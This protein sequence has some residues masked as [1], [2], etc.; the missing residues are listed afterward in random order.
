MINV[1]LRGGQQNDLP[2]EISVQS[3]YIMLHGSCIC[4]QWPLDGVG[5][6]LT[7]QGSGIIK[8]AFHGLDGQSYQSFYFNSEYHDVI[9]K[10]FKDHGFPMHKPINDEAIKG[11]GICKT[12]GEEH[13]KR[14]TRFA[15]W[16]N[17]ICGWC[18]KPAATTNPEDYNITT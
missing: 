12:C 7:H 6:L 3:G 1:M 2:L 17:G 15:S 18:H 14:T 8:L 4:A 10:F 13:G 11:T 9:D 16:S 5:P